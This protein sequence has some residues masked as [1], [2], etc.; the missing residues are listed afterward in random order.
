MAHKARDALAVPIVTITTSRGCDG[1]QE[2]SRRQILFLCFVLALDLVNGPRVFWDL[3]LAGWAWVYTP[4]GD[5]NTTAAKTDMSMAPKVS[6]ASKNPDFKI[7][8]SF[9]PTKAAVYKSPANSHKC[10][11]TKK[12]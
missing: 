7:S 6:K 3:L 8:K 2:S 5:V 9:N 12:D 1:G 11:V 4:A 10:P